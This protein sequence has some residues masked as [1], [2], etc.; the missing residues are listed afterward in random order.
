MHSGSPALCL[1]PALATTTGSPARP[2]DP[3]LCSPTSR[4]PGV[5]F[6]SLLASASK[7][8]W[9]WSTMDEFVV[10]ARHI[11]PFWSYSTQCYFAVLDLLNCI[12]I[13][14]RFSVLG[15]LAGENGLEQKQKKL[16][17]KAG[18]MLAFLL[19]QRSRTALLTQR[20]RQNS[21]LAAGVWHCRDKYSSTVLSIWSPAMEMKWGPLPSYLPALVPRIPNTHHL[22]GHFLQ[23]TVCPVF[24]LSPILSPVVIS[25]R[26]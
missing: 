14:L 24:V 20:E 19:P 16:S 18:Q 22:C 11:L 10:Q 13:R 23:A 5:R 6:F 2:A 3:S 7:T 8:L 4:T 17:W 15:K 1:Q 26:I 21:S 12:R 25:V 9:K